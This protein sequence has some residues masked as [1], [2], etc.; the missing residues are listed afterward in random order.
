MVQTRSAHNSLLLIVFQTGALGGL[1]TFMSRKPSPIPEA[2]ENSSAPDSGSSSSYSSL[3]GV[4]EPP[5]AEDG[6]AP[7]EIPAQDQD[8]L[9]SPEAAHSSLEM[10]RMLEQSEFLRPRVCTGY[11]PVLKYALILWVF[12]RRNSRQLP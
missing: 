9:Y 7:A 11:I 5:T 2:T 3:P 10:S 1:S 12:V 6:E 4:P 8:F